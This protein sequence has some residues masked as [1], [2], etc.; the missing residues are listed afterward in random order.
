MVK[1][2]MVNGWFITTR[3]ARST[4]RGHAEHRRR[5]AQHEERVAPA[6]TERVAEHAH[7]YAAEDGSRDGGNTGVTYFNDVHVYVVAND[8]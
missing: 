3:Q 7:R 6:G 5:D 1:Q 8:L 2:S 4:H